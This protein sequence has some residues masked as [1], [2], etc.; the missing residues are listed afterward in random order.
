MRRSSKACLWVLTVGLSSACGMERGEFVAQ[1]TDLYCDQVLACGDSAILTY[2]GIVEHADCE[3]RNAEAIGTW[4]VG[5]RFDAAAAEVCLEEMALQTCPGEGLLPTLPDACATV[6]VRCDEVPE[7][8]LLS[9]PSDDSDDEA[10]PEDTDL[11][12]DSDQKS[13]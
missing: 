6:Y 9:E 8:T 12:E 1:Y 11:P 2:E 3:E 4:G 5:C 10:P 7:D 13:K